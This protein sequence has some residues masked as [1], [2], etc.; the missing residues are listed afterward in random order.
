[1]TRH[2][3]KQSCVAVLM[4]SS[5]GNGFLPL[6]WSKCMHVYLRVSESLGVSFTGPYDSGFP[7]FMETTARNAVFHVFRRLQPLV[8]IV[9][10][11]SGVTNFMAYIQSTAER[12]F[13]PESSEPVF[14]FAVRSL[15]LLGRLKT[16]QADG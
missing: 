3:L 4:L 1:M 5:F 11:C 12:H 9:V 14:F 16:S 15:L 8:Y 10:V 2:G 7:L 6:A 13:E